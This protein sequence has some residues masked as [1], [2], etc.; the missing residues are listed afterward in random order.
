MSDETIAAALDYRRR[1]WRVVPIPA[2]QKGPREKG[3]QDRDMGLAEIPQRF[4]AGCNVGVI[5]GSRS[6]EL[7]DADLDCLEALGLADIYLPETGAIFG[8]P[9]K[10]R[11][12]WLHIAP[13]AR[14]ESFADPADG[15]M[16]VELR[17]DGPDGGAHQTVFP[18]SPHPSGEWLERDR[19]GDLRRD[20]RLRSRRHRL[21]R[22]FR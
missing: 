3:W 19:H 22:L 17:A 4:A 14:Y 10:P 5:L 7:V 16:L 12:H 20:G 8:R 11:S 2:G 6:G 21:R 18:P 1:G 13:G 15:S 9:S